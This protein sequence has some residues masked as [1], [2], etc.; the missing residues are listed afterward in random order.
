MQSAI[1]VQQTRGMA[2]IVFDGRR[3]T[4]VA[5]AT[6]VLVLSVVQGF[7]S[8]AYPMIGIVVPACLIALLGV[9]HAQ[10]ISAT[11][12][13]VSALCDIPAHFGT[14][15]GVSALGAFTILLV[16]GSWFNW[17]CRPRIPRPLMTVIAAFLGFVAWGAASSIIWTKPTIEGLQGLAVTLAFVGLLL[18]A[19]DCSR[20]FATYDTRIGRWL[21]A[22]T[23]IA[24][25]LYLLGRY[26]VDQ[27]SPFRMGPRSF[28]LLALLG[29]SWLAAQWRYGSRT[30]FVLACAVLLVIG[31][32]L[33]RTALAVGLLVMALAQFRPHQVRGWISFAAILALAA[34]AFYAAIVHVRALNE[35]FFQGDVSLT[36]GGVGINMMGRTRFW[37]VTWESFL[38][39]PWIGHGAGSARLLLESE[40][41][42]RAQP[43]QDYLRILHDFGTVGFAF[44]IFGYVSLLTMLARTWIGADRHKDPGADVHLAALLG[45]ISLALTMMTDN[46]VVY[47]FVMGPMAVLV[48]TSVGRIASAENPSLAPSAERLNFLSRVSETR[49]SPVPHALAVPRMRARMLRPQDPNK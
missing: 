31:I 48:G 27:T 5:I 36:I 34:S 35:R 49:A 7:L 12:L 4:L 44:W 42:P 43:H 24:G 25:T 32:S 11:T 16:C 28:A 3:P 29:L 41:G 14:V 20:R 37:D 26:F 1:H 33:S 46:S 18:V 23:L 38:R 15:P 10:R 2:P 45:A 9:T 19:A 6:A 8:G 39:S 47:M 40:F 21:V 30:S 22:S 17:M 13:G